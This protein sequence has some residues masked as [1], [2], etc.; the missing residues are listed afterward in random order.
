MKSK[1]Y[2]YNLES[3]KYIIILKEMTQHS[4][5][6]IENEELLEEMED[7]VEQIEN[8]D[9]E[10]DEEK[11]EDAIH[12]NDSD[13]IKRLKNSLARTQ[14][15]Y[16]NFQ[17]RTQRDKGDMIFFLKQDIFKKIL[18][19]ID[20][21]E[22]ILQNTPQE[23]QSG[24]I[25]DGMKLVYTKLLEDINRLWV[26]SFESKWSEVDPEKHDVMTQVPWEEGIIQD[27]FEKGYELDWKVLRH[28]K[29][30]VGNGN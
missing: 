1:K 27:E 30:V 5:D 26:Q 13:E 28:A 10:I 4:K 17:N 18:P 24:A 20:D 22:R 29:V 3:S 21:L 12:P 9:W 11:L 2:L 14:A 16:Q 19:R 6:D 15:D 23:E 25:F 8:E 7:E